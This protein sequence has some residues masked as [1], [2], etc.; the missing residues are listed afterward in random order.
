MPS[1]NDTTAVLTRETPGRKAGT[2]VKT[3]LPQGCYRITGQRIESGTRYFLLDGETWV[4]A[5]DVP[6]LVVG[7]ERH[8]GM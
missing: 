3:A 8:D 6:V 5:L 7:W 2:G 4:G 1:D